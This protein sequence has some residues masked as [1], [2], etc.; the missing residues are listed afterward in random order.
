MRWAYQIVIFTLRRGLECFRVSSRDG[1]DRG[2]DGSLCLVPSSV[3]DSLQ[4]RC[5][6]RVNRAHRLVMIGEKV[7]RNRVLV[8]GFS[9]NR[10]GTEHVIHSIASKLPEVPFDFLCYSAPVA[11]SDLFDPDSNNRFFTI[12]VKIKH[13]VSYF[14]QLTSFM[15]DHAGEYKALWMNINDASNIDILKMAKRYG[16]PRRIVHMHSNC[17]PDV[18]VTQVFHRIN[19]Q[20]CS[21]LATDYWA[22]SDSAGVFLFHGHSFHVLQNTV[23]VAALAYSEDDRLAIRQKWGISQD[24]HLIG[25][26]GRLVDEKRP[27]FLVETLS[28]LVDSG[29]DCYLMFVGEGPLKSDLEKQAQEAGVLDRIRFTGAQES[30]SPYLSAFDVFA[31]PSVFEGLGIA[32]IEAQFNGLPCVVSDGIVDEAIISSGVTRF[33]CNDKR[34][35]LD[36]LVKVKRQNCVLIDELASKYDS[37]TQISEIRN[38]FS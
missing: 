19:R 34:A 25:T 28:L 9:N 33:S 1:R 7:S 16:I 17:I 5:V 35:W 14:R 27:G 12:P 13:P 23:D 10:A 15:R 4:T 32:L 2:A 22:C 38:L 31:F 26:V 21:D 24:A 37:R 18:A 30:V 6:I 36:A 11:Y 8:W 29:N 3:I 20:K